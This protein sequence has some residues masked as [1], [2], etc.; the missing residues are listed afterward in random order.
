MSN[1]YLTAPNEHSTSAI[2]DKK[3]ITATD[4]ESGTTIRRGLD[5]NVIAQR[6]NYLAQFPWKSYD[7]D[8][9]TTTTER[10]RFYS[11]SAL[12]GD[13]LATFTFTYDDS[14]KSTP[15]SGSWS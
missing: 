12:A 3:V 6:G 11:E 15:P 1:K 9:P 5:V 14:S 13:L 10:Y 4:I 7:Y 8:E 2:G